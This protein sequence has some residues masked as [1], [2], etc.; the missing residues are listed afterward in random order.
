MDDVQL[1]RFKSP[2]KGLGLRANCARSP[3][4]G[5]YCAEPFA[6]V[7]NQAN[8]SS[9]CDSCLIR[10]DKGLLRCSKCKCAFYCD[11][12]CQRSHWANHKRECPLLRVSATFPEDAVRLT[13]N[14]IL[15]LEKLKGKRDASE[16]LYSMLE[17]TSHAAKANKRMIEAF[18]RNAAL[19]QAFL[20]GEAKSCPSLPMGLT[21]MQLFGKIHCNSFT[22]TNNDLED[23][24]VGIYPS[25]S[26]LNHS[27]EPNCVTVFDGIKL[28]LRTVKDVQQGE[29]LLISY[30]DTLAGS[31]DRQSRLMHQYH[32]T[33]ECRLCTKS[34]ADQDMREDGVMNV[35]DL[36]MNIPSMHRM[37][38]ARD[39][40][41]ALI[42]AEAV[43]GEHGVML[44]DRNAH[45]VKFV[46]TCF[47]A[48]IVLK[49]WA[50]AEYYGRRLAHVYKWYYTNP[51]P[52]LGCHLMKLGKLQHFLGQ[53]QPAYENLKQ[54]STI[55]NTT[56]GWCHPVMHTLHELIVECK[57]ELS[58]N[59][60]N[61]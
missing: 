45:K 54:A 32:F 11:S 4:Q 47:D 52:A 5:L 21:I 9:V 13:A 31:C 33:C 50:K 23:I 56:H 57:M 37:M 20:R 61:T 36:K 38:H 39:H 30:I 1:S 27:C 10:K 34:V 35:H 29:E 41:S 51:H 40:K 44:P 59:A 55:M 53:L 42:L 28:L 17:L 6:Y 8:K 3:G 48:C 43:L 12:S 19:L 2:G 25:L 46:E 18:N 14:V 15:K 58:F 22:I 49:K 16:E 26:L 7:K 60:A 24:G